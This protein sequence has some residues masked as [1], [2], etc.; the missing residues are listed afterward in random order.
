[1]QQDDE[2]G[3]GPTEK[4][5]SRIQTR[6]LQSAVAIDGDDPRSVLYQHTVFAQTSLPYRNPGDVVREWEREQG[7]AA[8]KISAGEVRD[9][10]RGTWVK[11][12]LPWGTKARLVLAHLNG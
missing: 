10:V 7:A 3:T 5:L 1:M 12:G 9:T 6:L 4:P 11:L 8:L 2:S